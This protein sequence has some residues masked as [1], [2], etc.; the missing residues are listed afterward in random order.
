LQT[1]EPLNTIPLQQFIQAVKSAENSRAKE[2]KLDIATAK[3]LAFTLG[4]VMSRLHG[5]LEKL[6]AE[7]K[8]NSNETIEINLDGGAKF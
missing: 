1:V 5:D 6:V 4:V 3:N 7:S 2:V 8:D